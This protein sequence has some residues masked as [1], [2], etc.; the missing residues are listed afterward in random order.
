MRAARGHHPMPN[1]APDLVGAATEAAALQLGWTSPSSVREFLERYP[2][3][4]KVAIALPPLPAYHTSQ[5][6]AQMDLSVEIDRG[7]VYYDV[8]PPRERRVVQR[9]PTLVVY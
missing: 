3:G 8:R 9:R 6:A 7:D 2:A 4:T 5:T 1:A